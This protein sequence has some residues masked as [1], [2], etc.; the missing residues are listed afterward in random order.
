MASGR[1]SGVIAAVFTVQALAAP[2]VAVGNDAWNAFDSADNELR[3]LEAELRVCI[4][5]IDVCREGLAARQDG[6]MKALRQ[7]LAD[8][9]T[10]VTAAN[11]QAEL[12]A[13]RDA[14]QTARAARDAKAQGLVASSPA[15]RAANDRLTEVTKKIEE[16]TGRVAVL[17]L[18]E[19][20]ELV[21]LRGE[22]HDL[23]RHIH[24]S[25][26]ALW[27]RGEVA[28][29]FQAADA[30]YRAY[31]AVSG[32][33]GALKQANEKVKS[34]SKALDAAIAALPLEGSV[35]QA[36][37]TRRMVLEEEI[38]A[39]KGNIAE[40]EK[41]LV[42]SGSTVSTA[43]QVFDRKSKEQVER[44]VSLWLPP[45]HEVIRGIIIAHPMVKGLV[46]SR[47]TRLAAAREGLG[48]MVCGDI[49]ADPKEAVAQFDAMFETFAEASGHP[50][51]RGAPIMVG[52]LS[53]SVLATRNIACV[54]PERVFGVVHVAGGNMHQ[55]P[56]GGR[57]MIEVPFLAHNGEFEWCGPEGG[58]H[59]SGKA[60][61]R[62]EYG[63]QTQW[64]MI[65]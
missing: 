1:A 7:A 3:G 56:D 57:G 37:V 34:A 2:L 33:S 40:M 39:L 13:A 19:V 9:E 11:A 30:A 38:A 22:K 49:P 62:L 32:E 12:A 51:I 52:G 55:M 31:G 25:L 20:Q 10:A 28:A 5:A 14:M 65:R 59:A 58:G 43:I 48:M 50:E 15:W 29:E 16:M 53:A 54:A 17:N 35:G 4:A 61:I 23:D 47:A 60:G 46:T 42:G 21:R 44:K 26:R 27:S 24:G 41:N 36:L 6:E 64:V 45:N 8:A 18:A 63:Q